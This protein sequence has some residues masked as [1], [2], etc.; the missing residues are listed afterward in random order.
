MILEKMFNEEYLIESVAKEDF[1]LTFKID[2]PTATFQKRFGDGKEL[3]RKLNRLISS[4]FSQN[5]REDVLRNLKKL[6]TEVIIT[7]GPKVA[8]VGGRTVGR[9]K[10]YLAMDTPLSNIGDYLV[11][12]II[13]IL[14]INNIEGF[15]LLADQTDKIVKKGLKPGAT[16][17]NFLIG[18]R[19]YGA[20]DINR[21]EEPLA[22]FGNASMDFSLLTPDA[23]KKLSALLF[24]GQVFN[25]R[26][27]KM[28]VDRLRNQKP[29]VLS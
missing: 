13:H 17:K 23:I 16:L 8:Q 24:N 15:R 5:I 6:K 2:K 18:K 26:T 21:K 4:V 12:E 22:Y 27:F 7:C 20:A 28:V 11:H 9:N 29:M 3:P 1:P 14:T 10:I 25:V 19:G